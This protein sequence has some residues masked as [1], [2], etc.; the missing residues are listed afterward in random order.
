MEK[1]DTFINE[2]QTGKREGSVVTNHTTDSLSADEKE[3][4]RQLRK[5]LESVGITPALFNQH[6][7]LIIERLLKAIND[8]DLAEDIGE[9]LSDTT[10]G[11]TRDSTEERLDTDP[12]Y[13]HGDLAED[14]GDEHSGRT[15]GSTEARLATADLTYETT[16]KAGTR[17]TKTSPANPSAIRWIKGPSRIMKLLFRVTNS[18]ILTAAHQG[19]EGLVQKFLQRGVDADSAGWNSWRPLLL[20]AINGHETVVRL[21]LET[22]K[23]DVD[24]KDR[25]GRTPLNWAAMNKHEAVVKLL[26]QSS[27]HPPP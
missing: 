13:R 5:E 15:Q 17:R 1:L 24:L 19:K 26:A 27:P 18:S 10:S 14:P 4:W 25:R 20:A 12:T 21:L 11:T 23:V 7:E 9:E 6:R 2:V 22:G 8:G 3:A 16:P